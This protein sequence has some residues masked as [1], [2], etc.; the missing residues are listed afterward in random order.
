MRH[1]VEPEQAHFQTIG[2]P[3][4][5]TSLAFL[6]GLLLLPLAIETQGQ[7]LPD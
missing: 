7:P 3:V 6:A 5:L 1:V 4:A 2:F